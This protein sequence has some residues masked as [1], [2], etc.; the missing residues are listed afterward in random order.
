MFCVGDYITFMFL[1][2]NVKIIDGEVSDADNHHCHSA[3]L[4]DS[5]GSY[6]HSEWEE[7]AA[8]KSHNHQDRDLILLI[9]L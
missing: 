5:V 1:L 9:R 2:F 6:S 3:D 4:S 8:E 7:R